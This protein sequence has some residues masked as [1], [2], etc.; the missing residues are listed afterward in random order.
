M[1]AKCGYHSGMAKS[2]SRRKVSGRTYKP[3]PREPFHML[4]A[5]EER[6]ALDRLATKANVSRAEMVR[7]L[8]LEA[9]D[10]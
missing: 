9:V 6:T 2:Q 8:I 7:Q 5:D 3:K 1:A 4:L 10:G